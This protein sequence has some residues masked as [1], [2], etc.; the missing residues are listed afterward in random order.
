MQLS[1]YHVPVY[2]GIQF[3]GQLSLIFDYC[4][5]AVADVF[6]SMCPACVVMLQPLINSQPEGCFF[7]TMA[8]HFSSRQVVQVLK[9]RSC[10]K[11]VN[12]VIY[13]TPV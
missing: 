1:D 7:G 11:P 9:L 8:M 3:L 13:F 4:S 12:K 2:H 10:F 5:E 6:Y